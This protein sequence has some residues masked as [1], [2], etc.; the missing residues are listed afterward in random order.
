MVLGVPIPGQLSKQKISHYNK[1][2]FLGHRVVYIPNSSCLPG[3][4]PTKPQEE[5]MEISMKTNGA[6]KELREEVD[7]TC[8]KF[9]FAKKIYF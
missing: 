2:Y 5:D 4:D 9:F 8:L 7:R 1:G 6:I 3:F